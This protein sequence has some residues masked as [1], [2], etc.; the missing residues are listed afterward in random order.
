MYAGRLVYIPALAALGVIYGALFPVNKMSAEAGLPYIG[1]VFWFSL[2][3][4]IGL[5][6]PAALKGE[7]PRLTIPHIRVY[8]RSWRARRRDSGAAAHIRGAE[9]SGRHHYAVDDP[10]AAA[11]LSPVLPGPHRALSPV[12]GRRGAVRPWGYVADPDPRGQPA[13]AGYGGLG[14]AGV[15]G[16]GLLRRDQHAG[17][18]SP[19]SGIAGADDGNGHVGLR[20]GDAGAGHGRHRACLPLSRAQHRGHAGCAL[21]PRRSRR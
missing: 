4:T 8:G 6:I 12:R 9:A 15:G 16:A 19:A 14:A 10:G 3:A 1:Y 18:L 21:M 20:H 13:V 7:L 17:G 2:I 5:A 11:H